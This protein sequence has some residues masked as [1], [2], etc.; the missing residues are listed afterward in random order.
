MKPFPVLLLIVVS[1]LGQNSAAPQPAN[2]A[3]AQTATAMPDSDLS[4]M[5]SDLNN[6][7]S[8]LNAMG[9][10]INTVRDPAVRDALRT[11]E[12]MWMYLINDVQGR[13]NA[14]QSRK[15]K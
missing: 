4:R 13:I 9:S 11:N 10:Q 12:Q 14:A 5:Q 15:Q 1:V 3:P 6:L 7:R 2:S 8:M